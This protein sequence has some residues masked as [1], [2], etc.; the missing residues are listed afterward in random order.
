M[1]QYIYLFVFIAFSFFGINHAYADNDYV[2]QEL[3]KRVQQAQIGG[4][5]SDFYVTDVAEDVKITTNMLLQE[6]INCLLDNAVK[7]AT[8]ETIQ[9]SCAQTEGAYSI[10]VSN[11]GPTIHASDAERIFV[12]FVR[13]SSDE[14]TLGVGLPLAKCLATS[15]GY[16]LTLDTTYTQGARYIISG[17]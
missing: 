3:A 2:E 1:K 13:L 16:T 10:A 11:V 12:P 4:N 17:L 6:L 5:D 8:G 7:Y 14:H 15:M 9:L